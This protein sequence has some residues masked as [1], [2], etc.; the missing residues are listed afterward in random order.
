LDVV[1]KGPDA[2]LLY[3]QIFLCATRLA[4]S[5][6]LSHEANVCRRERSE[7]VSA[8]VQ[9][10][11]TPPEIRLRCGNTCDDTMRLVCQSVF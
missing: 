6:G 1:Q 3:A 7:A 5:V 2:L 11:A 9:E 4:F 10:I 8:P